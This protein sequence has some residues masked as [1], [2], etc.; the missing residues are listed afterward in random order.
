MRS[1]RTQK[2]FRLSIFKGW[3]GFPVTLAVCLISLLMLGPLFLAL[4][5]LQA[6]SSGV[7]PKKF[8]TV[9]THQVGVWTGGRH[10]SEAPALS[11]LAG[12][13]LLPPVEKRLPEKPMV[14]IPPEQA[15]P[16]G[17]S[18]NQ[19]ATSIKGIGPLS[20]AFQ[21]GLIQWDPHMKELRPEVAESW[22]VLDDGR[23]FV[24]HLRPG[25]KWSDGEPFT[26][27]DIAFWYEN[28]LQNSELTP[29]P[30]S[31]FFKGG[32]FA[33]LETP[34][35]H[36]VIF[37]F[38]EP[39]GL[40]LRWVARFGSR[41]LRYPAH[42]FKKIHPDFA[43]KI[44]LEQQVHTAGFTFWY[45]LFN[46]RA[47]WHNP[48]A[49][50]LNPWMLQRPPPAS[51]VVFVRNP[52]YWKVDPEGRQ[53]PYLDETTFQSSSQ[54]TINL[55]FIN[56]EAGM[57][58]VN[59]L[60]RDYPLLVAHQKS[61][62]YRV[63]EWKAPYGSGVI[64]P[65][66]NHQDPVLRN[67]MGKT[68]FR[69]ALSLAINR[70]EIRE[71][72]Y[73]GMGAPRQMSPLEHL[74]IF[75]EE[76]AL[77]DTRYDPEEA[78]RLLDQLG[79]EKRNLEGIRLL[80][81]G[82]PLV[83]TIEMFDQLADMDAL[84][85]VAETWREAGVMT[86]VRKMARS[87]FYARMPARLHDIAMG[88][89]SGMAEPLLDQAYF[90]PLGSGARHALAY[91]SWFLS[92]GA[93]GEEPPEAMRRIWELYQKIEGTV[94]EEKQRELAKEILRIHA[95]NRWLIGLVGDLPALAL[96]RDDFRNVPDR[97]VVHSTR[98]LTAPEIYAIERRH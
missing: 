3:M 37:I 54:G 5:K 56:G 90:M 59:V 72:L 84:L 48:E 49:P 62:H 36:T 83:V 34:D 22:E 21:E 79:L 88:G 8:S 47:E 20:A 42:Y 52:Y 97:A 2:K 45:Q 1:T 53:L 55:N 46:D 10:F 68:E 40:F 24:F 25:M 93:A 15:G 57:Q 51:R 71:V 80:P 26:S 74:D 44:S 16:Y 86:H 76:L 73:Y 33:R 66:L 7:Q 13:G 11:E 50:T 64:M 87:L 60:L 89:N 30:P 29:V 23:K 43:D 18:W 27:A 19:F 4:M 63:L 58:T 75:D 98:N 35:A 67:L 78:N 81:D 41:M 92:G 9:G 28:V 12:K 32:N 38:A 96:V 77:R 70:D 94:D 69:R 39:Q 61:G 6:G 82:R 91:V 65:N 17:G 85:L 14:V 95:E 31:G